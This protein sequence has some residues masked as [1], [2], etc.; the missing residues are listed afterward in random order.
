[1]WTRSGLKYQAKE[2]LRGKYWKAFVVSLLVSLLTSG[3]GSYGWGFNFGDHNVF[4]RG[5]SFRPWHGEPF[6]GNF[7]FNMP[8]ETFFDSRVIILLMLFGIFAGLI[9][10]AYSIFIAPVIEVG[11]NRWYSRSRESQATPSIGQLFYM[12]RYGNFLTVVGSM[13]WKNLF[14]FLWG[15]LALIPTAVLAVLAIAR[16]ISLQFFR[17]NMTEDMMERFLSEALLLFAVWIIGSIAFSIPVIIKSYS[18]RMTPWILGDNARIGYK[19]ALKLSM[20][21][22]SGHKFDMF[23]LDLSF[24]G[25]FLLGILACGIG[26]I[27]VVP[28]YAAVQAELFA[29]LRHNA[30]EQKLTSMEEMGF[31]PVN[32]RGN[33]RENIVIPD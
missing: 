29:T 3:T 30:V 8:F 24:I 21:M 28:Y 4:S 20:S 32:Q 14:L 26:V 2:N 13:F 27:F 16:V 6:S 23:L 1:M 19:R 22:T 5:S 18:Y 7:S 12:F 25:W 9:A 10:L 15:L 17:Q 11:G 31:I 33:T